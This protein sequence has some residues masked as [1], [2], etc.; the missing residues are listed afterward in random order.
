MAITYLSPFPVQSTQ[1]TDLT[2][3]GITNVVALMGAS[4]SETQ[5]DLLRDLVPDGGSIWLFPDGDKAGERMAEQT[6]AMLAPYRFVRWVKLKEGEQP[7]DLPTEGLQELLP[8][9]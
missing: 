4:C 3:A 5:A 9:V 7:T 6:L 2:Q 8:V 1:T